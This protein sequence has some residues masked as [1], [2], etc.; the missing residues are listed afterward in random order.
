[1]LSL[2]PPSVFEC[3]NQSLSNFVCMSC[4]LIPFQRV[5]YKSLP[6]QIHVTTDDQSVSKSWIRAPCGSRDRIQPSHESAGL[7][8]YPPIVA[9]QRL[10]KHVSAATKN[11]WRRRFLCGLCSPQNFSFYFHLYMFLTARLKRNQ[12]LIK[13][14][15]M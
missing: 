1:M 11:C 8:L 15:V 10:G 12:F 9:R 7:S 2:P 13:F 5:T 6:C 3:L 14:L 4:H